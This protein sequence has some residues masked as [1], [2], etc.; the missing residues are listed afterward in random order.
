MNPTPSPDVMEVELTK[1]CFSEHL[2]TA[3]LMRRE[4]NES[5]DT[6][7]PVSILVPDHLGSICSNSHYKIAERIT[8]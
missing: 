7:Y 8:Q 4:E 1:W 3:W 6:G 2:G 5:K